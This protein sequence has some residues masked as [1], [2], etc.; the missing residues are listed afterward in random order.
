MTKEER[1]KRFKVKQARDSGM[2]FRAIGLQMGF[3]TSRARTLYEAALR[4]ERNEKAMPGLTQRAIYA[5]CRNGI[6]T[7]DEL[8]AASP[9]TIRQTRNIGEKTF[10]LI[11]RV[12]NEGVTK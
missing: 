8:M 5:L 11:M 4:L 12:R 2:T 10:G 7:L 9:E 1:E 6:T 3:S